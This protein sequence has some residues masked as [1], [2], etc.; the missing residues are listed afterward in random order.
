M[1]LEDV[2]DEMMDR[3]NVEVDVDVD[4]VVVVV[5]NNVVVGNRRILRVNCPFL[6]VFWRVY[7]IDS[8][9]WL[10]LT[11]YLFRCLLDDIAVDINI[12]LYRCCF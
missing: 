6:F 3:T 12:Y 9:I 10:L 5:H 2:S 8:L 7:V 1:D 11:L 4:R